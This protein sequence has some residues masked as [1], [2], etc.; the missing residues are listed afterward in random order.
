M[1]THE[2]DILIGKFLAGEALPEEAMRL[3]DWK[4][5][6]PENQAYYESC[7][8]LFAAGETEIDSKQAWDQ[9]RA[10]IQPETPLRSI[11]PFAWSRLA[12][13]AVLLIGIGSLLS[14]FLWKSPSGEQQ[15]LTQNKSKSIR[16]NDGTDVK[17]AANSSLT[18]T[19]SYGTKNRVV[20][21]KG[22]AYFHVDHDASKPF[23]VDVEHL[24]IKDLG[25][26]FDVNTSGDTIFIR[27]DEG[28][29]VIY[30]K[31]G[32]QITLEANESAYY[33]ISINEI[34][35]EVSNNSDEQKNPI[36]LIF[37]DEKLSD[38]IKTLNALYHT[39]IRLE[40]PDLSACRITTEFKDEQLEVILTVITETLGLSYEHTN[41]T[42]MLKGKNCQQ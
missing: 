2:I 33:L 10:Q 5:E 15:Y 27:V 16:L 35:I 28:K 26:K 38:V 24:Y 8:R 12:A 34:N 4:A 19:A 3:E 23:I 1:E 11:K 29:V 30:N 14:Y 13:V 9:L 36:H 31:Q 41:G 32:I 40:N 39:N 42:Y 18:A 17:L 22:S 7:E 6:H 37:D 20:R 25:T 21:L